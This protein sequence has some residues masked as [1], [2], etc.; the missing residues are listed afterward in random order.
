MSMRIDVTRTGG[1]GGNESVSTVDTDRLDPARRK[2]IEQLIRD[3]A[4]TF[5]RAEEPI[6]ADLMRYEITVQE[7]GAKRSMTWTDDGTFGPIKQLI[8]EVQELS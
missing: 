8:E 5:G 1:Y 6:G 3:A 4:A 2:R 7:G